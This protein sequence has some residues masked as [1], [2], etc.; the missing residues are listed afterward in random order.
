[1][2]LQKIVQFNIGI[3]V[4]SIWDHTYMKDDKSKVDTNTEKI[5]TYQPLI[6]QKK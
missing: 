2:F 6:N 3:Q 5:S 1:M 4:P